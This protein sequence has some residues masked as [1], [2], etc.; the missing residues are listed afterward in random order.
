MIKVEFKDMFDKL[1][2]ETLTEALSYASMAF[3]ACGFKTVILYAGTD[4]R[5]DYYFTSRR[6]AKVA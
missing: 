4:Q 3:D 5:V 2:V 1:H 6:I